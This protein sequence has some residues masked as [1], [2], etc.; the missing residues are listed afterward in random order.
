MKISFANTSDRADFTYF[1]GEK[2]AAN[3]TQTTIRIAAETT[4]LF[5]V[6]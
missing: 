5:A 3:P 1:Q 2:R 6:V 4:L